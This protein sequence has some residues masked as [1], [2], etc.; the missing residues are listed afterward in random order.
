MVSGFSKS[1]IG[2]GDL[3]L[4]NLFVLLLCADS[5]V[6]LIG[7]LESNLLN[8]RLNKLDSWVYAISLL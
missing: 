6:L 7:L 5:G 2:G 3:G 1:R 8:S 4:S